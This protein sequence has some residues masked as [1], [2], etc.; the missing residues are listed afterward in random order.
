[1]KA[2]RKP[3]PAEPS[4]RDQLSENFLREFQSDFAANGADVIQRLRLKSPEK[5][6][7]IAAR[8]IAATEPSAAKGPTFNSTLDIG[9]YL[10]MEAGA[11]EDDINDDMIL[12]A[13]EAQEKLI[14]TLEVIIASYQTY[15][16]R[17]LRQ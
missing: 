2:A 9:R 14:E 13:C 3:K 6:V 1:M 7:E 17:G 4:L 10:L 8:L 16:T 5:Y 15:E 12:Q 11:N